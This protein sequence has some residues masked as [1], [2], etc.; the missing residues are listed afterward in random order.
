MEVE[1]RAAVGSHSDYGARANP[2]VNRGGAEKF[3]LLAVL[4]DDQSSENISR[5]VSRWVLPRVQVCDDY[6]KPDPPPE[7]I[8]FLTSPRAPERLKR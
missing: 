6:L 3:L 1:R 2:L 5:K 8:V 4:E 7:P